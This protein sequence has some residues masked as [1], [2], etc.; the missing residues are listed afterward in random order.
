MVLI[1]VNLVIILII[2]K[3]QEKSTTHFLKKDK[4]KCPFLKIKNESLYDFFCKKWF[5][6]KTL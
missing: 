6:L 3:K 4:N 2:E 5:Y 1:R